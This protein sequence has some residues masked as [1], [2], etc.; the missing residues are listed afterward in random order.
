[1]TVLAQLVESVQD[2]GRPEWRP[3]LKYVAE[4]HARRAADLDRRIAA[5]EQAQKR[6]SA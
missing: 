6:W 2:L 3:M 5:M 1:M 4:L